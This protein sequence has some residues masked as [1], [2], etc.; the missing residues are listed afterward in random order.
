M[1]KNFIILFSFLS[2]FFYSCCGDEIPVVI[3]EFVVPETEKVVLIEELT[4]VNCIN[5]PDGATTLNNIE[6]QYPGKIA[7]IAIHAGDLSEP[8]ENSKYDLRCEDGINIEKGWT[9]LG[10]PA[11]AIDRVIFEDGEVPVSGYSSW[12]AYIQN[13]LDEENIINIEA[14]TNF[15]TLSRTGKLIISITPLKDLIGKFK[16]YAA[17]TEDHIVDLQIRKNGSI[18]ENYEFE[19]VLRD[20]ITPFDGFEISNN[21]YKNTVV[22]N[23][24]DFSL[25][26]SD[27]TWIVK[28]M[29][30]VAFVTA[31]IGNTYEKVKNTKKVKLLK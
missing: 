13:Q 14:T 22:S 24:Y 29:N 21:L 15:D 12:Q 26:N 7:V 6:K 18:D 23:T 2:L 11:A 16:L 4:G 8:F 25:P 10:K 9:Y 5:C 3:P 17:L 31:D 27:G 1:M 20:M 28:N 19:N 30:I